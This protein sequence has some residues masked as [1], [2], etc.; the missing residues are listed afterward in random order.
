VNGRERIRQAMAHGA[1]DRVPI[2][3]QLSI[4]HYLL[5]SG[6][7]PAGLWFSSEGFTQALLKLARE[8]RFDGVLINLPGRRE[9][10]RKGMQS[11]R[12]NADGSQDVFWENGEITHCPAADNPQHDSCGRTAQ[13]EI[14][15]VD[16]ETLYYLDPHLPGGSRAWAPFGI[17]DTATDPRCWPSYLFRT[18]D[19]VRAATQGEISVHSEVF[20]PFT[21]LMEL[22]G[23]ENALIYLLEEPDKCKA[24]LHAL[25]QGAGDLAAAQAAHGVDAVL[26][27]SAFAGGGFISRRQYEEFVLPCERETIRIA[28]EGG[29]PFVYT[30]TC[31]A[32]GDRLDLMIETGLDGIDTLDPPPLGTVDLQEAKSRFGGQVFFKG[33]IDSVNTLLNGTLEDVRHDAAMRVRIGKPGAGYILSSACSVAPRVEPE[34]LKVLVNVAETEGVYSAT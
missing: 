23:Y 26:I 11:I 2:M 13:P 21:Q 4:G 34:K 3:C 16:P 25:A 17:Q 28:R 6:V 1:P 14:D 32:I 31:G 15:E 7:R 20:S 8:Y 24:I 18:I 30:H 27:S 5:N 29:A 19:L 33:N 22:F 9:D 12:D 10:W